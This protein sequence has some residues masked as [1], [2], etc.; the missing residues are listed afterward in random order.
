MQISTT[1]CEL[2]FCSFFSNTRNETSD[3][4]GDYSQAI[5]VGAQPASLPTVVLK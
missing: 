4:A 2:P 3:F 5:Y 1:D